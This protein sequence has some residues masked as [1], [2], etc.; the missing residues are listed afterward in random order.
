MD[1]LN[2][3]KL[4]VPVSAI[5]LCSCSQYDSS[6]RKPENSSENILTE[7]SSE[8]SINQN[9]KVSESASLTEN[10]ETSYAVQLTDIDNQT[11]QPSLDTE[12][13]ITATPY[14]SN[15]E[16]SSVTII[17]SEETAEEI[18]ISVPH[19]EPNIYGYTPKF[20][21]LTTDEQIVYDE[22]AKGLMLF[23]PEIKFSVPVSENQ[24]MKVYSAVLTTIQQQ[25][26]NPVRKYVA[27]TDEQTG[28]IISIK[29]QYEI[30]KEKSYEMYNAVN[31]KADEIISKITPEM[32]DVD[33]IRLFHDT[34]ILN[35]S[36]S[37]D[38]ANASNAYGALI[39]GSAACEGYSRAMAFLC[40]KADIPCEI[41]TGNAG[42]VYHM[43]N[44]V[45]T[46]G[47][48]Y[49]IDLTWD[50]PVFENDCPEYIGYDYF[51]ISDSEISRNHTI[52]TSFFT[53]PVAYSS[54][55]QYYNYYD[56]IITDSENAEE[57]IINGINH[58]V[59]SGYN[60]AVFKADNDNI[61]NQTVSLIFDN[62]WSGFFSIIDRYNQENEFQI[63]KSNISLKKD[64][65]NFTIRISF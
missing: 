57:I 13:I 2:F 51:N 21:Q 29:P 40:G 48:W 35:C 22:I 61:F 41:V 44:M 49:H 9:T 31:S 34:V 30:L 19:P 33:I 65:D 60:F 39:E 12:N 32:T 28:N 20:Y 62:G 15:P 23:K 52:D 1:N 64:S 6:Y 26:Y 50:D 59:S 7:I 24:F 36:Y 46:D 37:F 42:G 63:N 56:Y 11:I 25:L 5:V 8:Y 45:E 54:D 27:N 16:V 55:A 47:K 43:W 3:I 4:I 53:Y 14:E 58:A 38:T 10:T 17:T 18:N